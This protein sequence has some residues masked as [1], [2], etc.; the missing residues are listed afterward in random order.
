MNSNIKEIGHVSFKLKDTARSRA[1]YE[2]TLGLK[3]GF[4]LQK[5]PEI[6]W[7]VLQAVT[8]RILAEVPGVCRVLY[9][10][11]PKPVGTIE[12]E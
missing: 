4:V 10:L 5:V 12:W 9:D 2:D 8:N 11:T 6:P 7:A 3:V 1:W